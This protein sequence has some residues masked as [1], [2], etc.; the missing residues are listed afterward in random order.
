MIRNGRLPLSDSNLTFKRGDKE[1]ITIDISAADPVA[2]SDHD[3]INTQRAQRG[4][5]TRARRISSVSHIKMTPAL[6]NAMTISVSGNDAPQ[7]L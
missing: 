1:P 3:A 7:S 2:G 5:H 6:D 4:Y